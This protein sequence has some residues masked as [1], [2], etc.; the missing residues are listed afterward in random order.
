MVRPLFILCLAALA[1]CEEPPPK[2]TAPMQLGGVEVS[3]EEL[4][5]GHGIYRKY[6]ASCHGEDGSGQ[7][8]GSRALRVQPRDFR[9]AEFL[10]KSEGSALPTDADLERTIRK[11]VVERG[12]PPWPGLTAEDR[13]AVVQYL[14]TFSPRW[15]GSPSKP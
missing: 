6:C 15:S 12:M 9:K 3:A 10:Y 7:G 5:R 11:G 2:F 14:K 13:H 1:A 8:P 4:N